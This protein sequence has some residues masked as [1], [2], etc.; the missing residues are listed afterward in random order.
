[1]DTRYDAVIIGAGIIGA[2]TAFELAKRGWKTLNVD[3]NPAVG[4]GTTGNSCAVI[5]THYS[6]WDGTAMAW[7]SLHYWKDWGNRLL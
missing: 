7:E 5:R 6:T 2:A 1:M 4:H 3:K